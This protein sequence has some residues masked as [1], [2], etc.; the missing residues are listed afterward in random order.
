MFD[1]L[2]RLELCMREC[3]AT[4]GWSLSGNCL[5]CFKGNLAFLLMPKMEDDQINYTLT[6]RFAAFDRMYDTLTG[7]RIFPGARM[8]DG[9]QP[10]DSLALMSVSTAM[11]TVTGRADKFAS[12]LAAKVVTLEDNLDF[13][14][15]LSA[16]CVRNFEPRLDFSRELILSCLLAGDGDAAV[17]AAAAARANG[18]SGGELYASVLTYVDRLTAQGDDQ[19]Y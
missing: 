1:K 6:Y 17:K 8:I 5:A 10:V 7:A 2:R 15:Y 4:F 18:D 16:R 19:R 13:L 14:R 9:T 11:R 3:A 12:A